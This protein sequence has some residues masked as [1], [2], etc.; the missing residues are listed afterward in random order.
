M[1]TFGFRYRGRY[2]VSNDSLPGMDPEALSISPPPGRL[3]ADISNTLSG[4]MV[5]MLPTPEPSVIQE[6]SP[7]PGSSSLPFSLPSSLPLP[8][9]PPTDEVSNGL[10]QRGQR[11]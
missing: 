10:R 5:T 1:E 9:P 11:D 2:C 6:D 3:E 4:G 8:S 7:T